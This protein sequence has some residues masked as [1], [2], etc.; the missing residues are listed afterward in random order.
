VVLKMLVEAGVTSIR[1]S[2]PR[3]EEVYVQLIGDR[4]LMI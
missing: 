1:T 2:M 4:S 3:L